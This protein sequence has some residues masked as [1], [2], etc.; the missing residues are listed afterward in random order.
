[1]SMS[2][3]GSR[4][5]EPSRF[6]IPVTG[7]RGSLIRYFYCPNM[8][9]EIAATNRGVMAGYTVIFTAAVVSQLAVASRSADG[10]SKVEERRGRLCDGIRRGIVLAALHCRQGYGAK[11][12][13]KG[14]E[15]GQNF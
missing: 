1:M 3:F 11:E 8:V 4:R 2:L 13:I 12:N 15:T 5:M 10:A 7:P 9:D 6:Q 14:K